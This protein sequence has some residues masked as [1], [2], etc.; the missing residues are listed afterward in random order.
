MVNI[1]MEDA[2]RF[3]LGLGWYGEEKVSIRLLDD[4]KKD[5]YIRPH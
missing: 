3:Q 4:I 1:M 5:G 2:T